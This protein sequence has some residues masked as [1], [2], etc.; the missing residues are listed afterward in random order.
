MSAP[1]YVK[2][3]KLR[4]ARLEIVAELY[5]RGYSYR[6]IR[7]EVMRRLDIRT[8]ALGSVQ[9]D[10]EFLLAEWRESRLSNID[11]LVQL[12]LERIDEAVTECWEQWELSKEDHEQSVTTKK[13]STDGSQKGAKRSQIE[14]RTADVRGLGNPAYISEIRAQLV[15]RRK[16]LG[17][18][19][20]ERA[21][22]KTETELT[23][24]EVESELA[25]LSALQKQ[26]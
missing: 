4:I 5:K 25:R 26:K 22:I 2:R 9:N 8:Y 16:L 3:H 7:D 20:P 21:V 23:R 1:Q 6:K 15:E 19:S 14:T 10:V 11:D 17:L 24:E 13:A 12:E 18:Y